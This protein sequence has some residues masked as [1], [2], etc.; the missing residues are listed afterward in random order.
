[1]KRYIC[2]S[3]IIFFSF[4][5]NNAIFSQTIKG[6]IKTI[7]GNTI[8]V[9][10]VGISDIDYPTI[11]EQ[12]MKSMQ[13]RYE[14]K[15]KKQH[16]KI[17]I[18]AGAT[19][20]SPKRKIISLPKTDSIYIENFTL[21][22]FDSITLNEVVVT[23]KQ[24]PF[25]IRGDTVKYNVSAY[26]DG[27]ER[28]LQDLLKRLPG[29]EVNSKTGEIQY[30]GRSIET[31]K[32]EDDD[33]FG[34]NYTIGTKNINVDIVEQVQV[35]ENYE[36]NHLLKGI[37]YSD[38][39]VL[40]LKLKKE[41]IDFSGNIDFG[42]GMAAD[43]NLRHNYGLNM[44]GI[45]KKYKSFGT[46]SYNNVGENNS[47]FD[48]FSN[49][50]TS[51][52]TDKNDS[53]A[54]K[55]VSE[56]APLNMLDN[57]RGNINN[58]IFGNYNNIVKIGKNAA[59]KTNVFYIGDKITSKDLYESN[60]N[61]NNAVFSTSDTYQT[62]KI[63]TQYRAEVE[64]KINTSSLSLLEYKF[65]IKS[66]DIKTLMD[67][68][69][70]KANHV[71][72][73]LDSKDFLLRNRVL[74]TRKISESKAIQFSVFQSSNEIPQLL[75]LNPFLVSYDNSKISN[76]YCD[77]SKQNIGSNIN[78]I[79]SYS[80]I[81]YNFMLGYVLNIS[82][83]YSDTSSSGSNNE[84]ST[85]KQINNNIAYQEGSLFSGVDFFLKC[86]KW[87]FKSSIYMYSLQQ[88]LHKKLDNYKENT[89]NNIIEP[90]LKIAYKLNDISAFRV[91]INYNA[92]PK[93]EDHIYT[94]P[95][96]ISNRIIQSN[97]ISLDLQKNTTISS[98]YQI[99]NLPKQFQFGIG[100]SYF[101]NNGNYY[102]EINI[103]DENTLMNFHYMPKNNNN[104]S[105]D[106]LC[107]KYFPVIRNT[108]RLKSNYIFSA[109]INTLN[110]SIIR[111]N[112]NHLIHNELFIKS[113]FDSKINFENILRINQ[114]YTLSADNHQFSTIDLNYTFKSILKFNKYWTVLLFSDYY[115]P[116]V[117]Q[118]KVDFLF[119]DASVKYTSKSKI[120]DVNLIIKNI[121]NKSVFTHYHTTDYSTNLSETN[122]EKRYIMIKFNYTL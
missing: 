7:E 34:S 121:L 86:N 108:I 53:F 68:V 110:K 113:I 85:I 118:Q 103:N 81:K 115:R 35:I 14:L 116:D 70:N 47:P 28:K 49:S 41:K 48:Y 26:L 112:Q 88:F 94:K 72:T 96:I 9:S 40:N 83:F 65:Q 8:N 45:S 62:T 60:Y 58:S 39:V 104:L 2:F 46:I 33:L 67:I 36:H 16:R 52:K 17:V 43:N 120:F 1:M 20:F 24:K 107:E 105:I 57:S 42:I 63:P 78:L 99:I 89:K 32:L 31:V 30:K 10:F 97:D 102:P 122:L 11:I 117:Q 59:L 73:N 6:E 93:I 18:E 84:V 91:T 101:I 92:T 13:G 114:N 21:H 109:Y 66:E 111:N 71:T 64:L 100:A 15:L 69:E 22:R 106:F 55:F 75:S 27:S 25:I 80:K 12:S 95:L 54:K 19:G 37:G 76:Q 4:F 23:S 79:G 82:D 56:Y 61:I 119:M 90:S 51:K 5:L 74:F 44:V 98:S 87:S 38:K 50:S 29:I 77:F 3:Y